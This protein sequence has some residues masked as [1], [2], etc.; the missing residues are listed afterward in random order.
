MLQPPYPLK[1]HCPRCGPDRN[2]DIIKQHHEDYSD[3]ESNHWGYI[4]YRILR[5]RG[6]ERIF[7]RLLNIIRRRLIPLSQV[8]QH[9]GVASEIRNG[10]WVSSFSDALS[11]L[12]ASRWQFLRPFGPAG[13]SRRR[14]LAATECPLAPA[15]DGI[16]IPHIGLPG[17][18]G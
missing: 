2:A 5:C 7:F 13:L 14:S 12:S 4:D 18:T 1:G 8:H 3:E 17:T 9:I 11:C 6:C 15:A 16:L 10:G